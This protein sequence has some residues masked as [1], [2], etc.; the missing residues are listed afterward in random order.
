[1]KTSKIKNIFISAFVALIIGCVCYPLSI[2]YFYDVKKLENHYP[3]FILVKGEVESYTF[4]KKRPPY[5]VSLSEI[6]TYGKWAIILSEDWA[7]YQHQGIDLSQLKIALLESINEKKVVRGASTISQQM[8]KNI[9]LDHSRSYL[10]K[11][12]ELIITYKVE[13][14][15]SKQRILEVYLNSIEYG[16]GVWGIRNASY[17]YFKK[18]P[19]KIN[20]REAS[21]LA[22]MLPS[23]KRYYESFKKKRLT[24]F[25]E[26]RVH[27]TLEKLKIGRIISEDE[28]Y[29]NKVIRMNW[30]NY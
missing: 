25:A 4:K 2:Y 28:L 12:K 14:H 30:E 7:F 9:Y 23:P 24:P 20:P 22:M 18:H 17:H 1:M 15:I 16:P 3:E 13:K 10:R 8:V 29:L 6:S 21:F 5:W 27:I 19:S 26:K 11:L